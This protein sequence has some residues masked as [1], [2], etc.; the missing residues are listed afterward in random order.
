[1]KDAQSIYDTAAR[2]VKAYRRDNAALTD[3]HSAVVTTAPC[4]DLNS[5]EQ[6]VDQTAAQQ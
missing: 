3:E 5:E 1:M 2:Q 4:Q 6:R